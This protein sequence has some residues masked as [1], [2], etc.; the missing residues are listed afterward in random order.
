MKS[1]SI[2]RLQGMRNVGR[3]TAE[4][5]YSLGIESPDD[6]LR[7]DPEQLYERLKA[8]SGGKLDPCV[9][10]QFR[11]AIQDRPWWECK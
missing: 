9:L 4:R 10:Y 2:E 1:E 3:I 6:M 7:A 5:L 8:L 11:G